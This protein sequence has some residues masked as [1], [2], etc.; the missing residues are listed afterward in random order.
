MLNTGE[1]HNKVI[2]LFKDV[3]GNR[4]YPLKIKLEICNAFI[5]AKNKSKFCR[6]IGVHRNLV[7][8]W[9]TKHLRVHGFS[10]SNMVVREHI[11]GHIP[12][13]NMVSHQMQRDRQVSAEE[14]ANHI[15]QT[16]FKP[17]AN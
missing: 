11:V 6:D 14:H 12:T 13:E 10:P 8:K 16:L 5:N 9:V 3:S 17:L 4:V 2:H 15:Q 1:I 7:G